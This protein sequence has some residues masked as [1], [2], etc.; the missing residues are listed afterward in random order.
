MWAYVQTRAF[1]FPRYSFSQRFITVYWETT[2][3]R[4]DPG[5]LVEFTCSSGD[6]KPVL[7][8]GMGS[9]VKNDVYKSYWRRGDVFGMLV[10][11][12]QEFD[13]TRTRKKAQW[14]KE[15]ENGWEECMDPQIHENVT[16]LTQ[17]HKRHYPLFC[18]ISKARP[19]IEM[20]SKLIH[21]WQIR[22]IE[23]AY[24][25]RNFCCWPGSK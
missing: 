6:R 4:T 17:V 16:A 14:G 5:S 23:C 2:L 18:I 22:W 8:H 7:S 20:P 15:L 19:F 21:L 12:Q 11:S 3:T 9:R 10:H 25:F 24:L 13:V 1:V